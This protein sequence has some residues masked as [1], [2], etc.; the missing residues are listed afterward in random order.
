MWLKTEKRAI[1]PQ[2]G[3]ADSLVKS[4]PALIRRI[5]NAIFVLFAKGQKWV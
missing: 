5:D 1:F 2:I 3:V 4:L